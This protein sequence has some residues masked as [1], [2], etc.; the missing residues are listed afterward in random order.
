MQHA[1]VPNRLP[2]QQN[3]HTTTREIRLI[4]KTRKHRIMS[5]YL[6]DDFFQFLKQVSASSRCS[7]RFDIQESPWFDRANHEQPPT[8]P[9]CRSTLHRSCAG[10][11]RQHL[12]E[13]KH[14]T[15]F[16]IH[17][18]NFWNLAFLVGLTRTRCTVHQDHV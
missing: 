16:Q 6:V 1:H 14:E 18:G 10:S 4:C 15:T 8:Q 2:S 7:R 9:T 5:F 17:N 12:K 13:K 11:S 3:L